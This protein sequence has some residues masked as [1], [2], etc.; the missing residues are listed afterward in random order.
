MVLAASAVEGASLTFYIP[1]RTALIGD[2]VPPSNLGNAMALQQVAFNSAR[3]VGPLLAGA[4]I[5]VPAVGPGGA[6]VLA[7]TF[8]AL[9]GLVVQTLPSAPPKGTRPSGNPLAQIAGGIAYVRAR[10]A[11]VVLVLTS[12]TVASLTFPYMAFLPALVKDIY[13]LGSIALGVL[14]ATIAVGALIAAVLCAMVIDG[15]HAWRWQA[16][17]S[18][19]FV[20]VL[21]LFAVAPVFPLAL[22]IGA[23]LGAGEIGFVSLNQGLAMRFS[24]PS[25]HGR[26]QSVLMMGF[27]LFGIVALP[28]GLLADAIGVRRTLFL[29]GA[30][31][32]SIL[33]CIYL[34]SR[35]SRAADD[36]HLP[37][38]APAPALAR[39]L[40]AGE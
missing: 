18:T 7:G 2:L 32:T 15:A 35:A 1:A 3:I 13:G 22:V 6:L 21:M 31:A 10:P 11:L 36:A 29:E 39:S 4:L 27:A 17:A 38:P 26:V 16:L 20:V 33:G 23:L 30:L 37:A 25:Y 8:F 9:S 40:E 24:D 14:N 12:Y 19:G 5:A 28:M 34:Y